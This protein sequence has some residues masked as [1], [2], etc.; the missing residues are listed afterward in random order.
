MKAMMM[1][2]IVI[3]IH[4]WSLVVAGCSWVL[5]RDGDKRVGANFPASNVWL[6]L[7]IVSFLPGAL[8][9]IPFGTAIDLPEIEGL[10][11][12]PLQ[13]SDDVTAGS[14]PFNF[15]YVYI[16]LC[17]C[18]M[19]RT[20]WRWSRLQGLALMS[21]TEPDVF[22]TSAKMPPLTLSWPRRA[23]VIPVGFEGKSAL[24]QHERAHLRHYDA[25]LT[26]ILLLIRDA[27]LQNLG[28]SYLVRQWRQAIEMRADHTAVKML[29]G[30]ERKDYASLL[31]NGLRGDMDKARGRNLPCPT[32]NLTSSRHRHVKMRLGQIMKNEPNVRNRRWGAAVF[33]ASLIASGIGVTVSA[34]TL[35]I[36]VRHLDFDPIKYSK[37]VQPQ[38]P[39]S[40]PG[41]KKDD[42]KFETRETVVNGKKVTQHVMVLGLVGLKHDVRRDGSIHN[43][44]TLFST[45]PCFE[46]NAKN[47][48][49]QWKTEPQNFEIRDAGVKIPFI[50]SAVSLVDLK[51]QLSDYLQ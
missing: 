24:I 46:A 14:S 49:A 18:F 42:V 1:I 9:L 41:L 43:P 5:Q 26:L 6:I 36:D 40:C 8:A 12:F 28:I 21:T 45:H 13:V 39:A 32:A 3:L 38:L 11:L 17:F 22:T 48:M 30:T 37:K 23:V 50:I 7:I 19:G 16:A 25:E 31:L 51:T 29:N 33:L 34:A 35:K 20:L 10:D 2:K 27:M 4:L 15:L 44:H 47:V